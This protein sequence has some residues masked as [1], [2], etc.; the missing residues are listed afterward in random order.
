MEICKV[1]ING[2][3]LAYSDQGQGIPVL[4]VHGFPLNQHMWRPQIEALTTHCRVITLDLRGHGQSDAPLWHFTLEEYA[5]DIKGLLDHLNLSHVVLVGLSMGGYI[6]FS[7]Y[8]KYR[9]HVRGLVLTDT[10][11]Q[12]DNEEGRRGRF[13]MAQVAFHQGTEPIAEAMLPKLLCEPSRNTRP[14]LTQQVKDLIG[15][16][17]I[18]GIV[19]D[20]IAMAERPDSVSL[21]QEIRCPTMVIVGELDQATPPSDARFMAEGISDALLRIIPEAAH[22]PNL[23]QPEQYN[24][25]IRSF[26]QSLRETP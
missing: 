21:L 18:S 19:V 14:D 5:D 26:V 16:N 9:K 25:Y 3:T 24:T 10:R 1:H 4:F 17:P 2:M 12:A 8:R 7:F 22:L 6:L 23:E 20:L 13:H 11:A 15:M